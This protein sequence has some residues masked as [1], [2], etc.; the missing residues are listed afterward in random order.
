MDLWTLSHCSPD[1]QKS[2]L[3]KRASDETT[4]VAEGYLQGISAGIEASQAAEDTD[5]FTSSISAKE[6][7]SAQLSQHEILHC[8]L[9]NQE[10]WRLNFNTNY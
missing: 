3:T 6:T 10:S 1:V 9:G 8:K 2:S 7:L 4:A 5:C